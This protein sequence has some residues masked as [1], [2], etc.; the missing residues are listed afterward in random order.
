MKMFLK[1]LLI[2]AKAI[3]AASCALALDIIIP[4][5]SS[6]GLDYLKVHGKFLLWIIGILNIFIGGAA[7]GG[8]LSANFLDGFRWWFVKA[9]NP[10]NNREYRINPTYGFAIG[11][12]V[13]NLLVIA[14]GIEV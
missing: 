11:V 7:C 3:L 4:F 8:F 1:V 6:N 14:F 2:V 9:Y 5:A 10:A 13:I 12:F